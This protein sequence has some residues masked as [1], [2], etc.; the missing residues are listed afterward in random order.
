[1]IA[2]LQIVDNLPKHALDAAM[3]KPTETAE[4]A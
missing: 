4:K 3:A 1:M 2:H